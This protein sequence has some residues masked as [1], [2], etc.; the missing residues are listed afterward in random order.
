MSAREALLPLRA[1]GRAARGPRRHRRD[2][3]DDQRRSARRSTGRYKDVTAS[4]SNFVPKPHT[5]YQWNGMQTREYF[6]W[7]GDYLHRRKRIKVVKIKQHDIETSLLEGILTRGDRRVSPG[8]VRG[9]EARRTDG[10]LEGVLQPG[11]VV[12]GVPRPGHRRGLLPHRQRPM[13]EKL[14]WDH[15]NV[16]KGRA[17]LE[18]EQERS[19]IQ[20]RVMAEAVSGEGEDEGAGRLRRVITPSCEQSTASSQLRPDRRTRVRAR[21]ALEAS[22]PRSNRSRARWISQ[23]REDFVP[24]ARETPRET[25][26][27]DDSVPLVTRR[28]QLRRTSRVVPGHRPKRRREQMTDRQV[29]LADVRDPAAVASRSSGR[30]TDRLPDPSPAT[31]PPPS[32]MYSHGSCRPAPISVSRSTSCPN[33]RPAGT[34]TIV[35]SHCP[36]KYGRTR[37]SPRGRSLPT[38]LT[39]DPVEMLS[40]SSPSPVPRPPGHTADRPPE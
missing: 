34:E 13:G 40:E 32:R 25:A 29:S 9:V 23:C 15:V 35:R 26:G 8:A 38:R 19:V 24:Q 39:C 27:E 10:R 28:K 11:T 20:L 33:E 18:K 5:P 36:S 17:Y 7:A 14:P 2:G 16:K 1:A 3:R 30:T 4:V 6:R 12:A 37:K 22:P 31:S 21:A